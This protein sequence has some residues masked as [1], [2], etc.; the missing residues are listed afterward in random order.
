MSFRSPSDELL[1]Q[2]FQEALV[3]CTNSDKFDIPKTKRSYNASLERLTQKW[4]EAT[5]RTKQVWASTMNLDIDDFERVLELAQFTSGVRESDA[6]SRFFLDKWQAAARRQGDWASFEID[7]LAGSRKSALSEIL[8]RATPNIE[9]LKITDDCTDGE[10]DYAPFILPSNLFCGYT[11]FLEYVALLNVY[12]PPNFNFASFS[13]LKTLSVY[14]E[15]QGDESTESY[16]GKWLG[17]LQQTPLLEYLTIRWDTWCNEG[18]PP[19]FAQDHINMPYPCLRNLKELRL[20]SMSDN[21]NIPINICWH[22]IVPDD[23][24]ITMTLSLAEDLVDP[25]FV[26]LHNI[27]SLHQDK[28]LGAIMNPKVVTWGEDNDCGF[29][30]RPT[31]WWQDVRGFLDISFLHF[32]DNVR[33]LESNNEYRKSHTQ[34]PFNHDKM[35]KLLQE[36][37]WPVC[38]ENIP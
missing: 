8:T 17:I 15:L 30:L 24:E 21:A 36:I 14:Q 35:Y 31:D 25:D 32:Y 26:T 9:S 23:C 22:L 19:S 11:P 33:S 34:N 3:I 6:S 38:F 18:E 13:A 2:V 10:V 12:F 27:I 28:I 7:L 5:R 37:L 1:A 20:H 4:Q 16:V 29:K